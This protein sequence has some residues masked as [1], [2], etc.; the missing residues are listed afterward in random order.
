MH[1]HVVAIH[2]VETKGDSPFL[3]MY[4]VAGESREAAIVIGA[5]GF[6]LFYWIEIGRNPALADAHP[7]WMA[8]LEVHHSEWRRLFPKFPKTKEDELLADNAPGSP[9]TR[10][11]AESPKCCDSQHGAGSKPSCLRIFL[12]VLSDSEVNNP[13]SKGAPKGTQT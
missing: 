8:S 2:N 13:V 3:V 9:V 7:E 10:T 4:F 5:A 12:T 11:R 1:K 6:D